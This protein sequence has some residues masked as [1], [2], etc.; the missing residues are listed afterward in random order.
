MRV[1]PTARAVVRPQ[2]PIL[3]VLRKCTAVI[4]VVAGLLIS[5]VPVHAAAPAKWVPGR[6]VVQ[7]RAGVSPQALDDAV[8]FYG[9]KVKGQLKAINAH[10]LAVPAGLEQ[11]V[12]QELNSDGDIA[13]AERERLVAPSA[14]APNDPDYSKAWH[15]AKMQVTSAWDVTRGS[16][17]TVAVLDTG[18]DA[19]QPDLAGQ[20]LPGHNSADGS[21]NTSDVFGHGTEVAGVIAALTNNGIGV[22]SIA[23]AVRILPVRVTNDSKGLASTY[24]IAQGLIWAADHGA[25][26]ANISYNVTGDTLV[27][28]AA[29]Y[30]HSKG[31]VVVVAAGNSDADVGTTDQPNIITV[32]ATTSSDTKASW[33]NYGAAVDVSAPGVGIW[34]TLRG[35][36]YGA[37]SGT[38]FASPATA[39]VAAL[40]M[41]ANPALTPDQ[42]QSVLENSAVDL[43]TPGRDP[44]FGYGRVDAAAAVRLA[45]ATGGTDAQ[46]PSVS[47]TTPGN[48]ATV[49]T[50]IPVDVTASDNVSVSSVELYAGNTKVGTDSV[51]PYQFSWDPTTATPGQT[52]T[53]TAYAHD[54]SG[55]V[56]SASITV[57]VKDQTPPV[58]TPP[59]DELV[60]ATGTLTAVN[61]GTATA[62][63]NFDGPL[64]PTP[65]ATGPFTVGTHVI[66]WTAVDAAG[67]V[68]TATQQIVVTTAD[69]TPPVVT[70]P[71]D[72]TVEATGPDTSVALG[73]GT[74][75]DNVDGNLVPTPDTT[76]PFTVGTHRVVWS[77]IDAAG[78]RGTATQTVKVVDTTPPVITVPTAVTVPAT[79]YVT[80]VTLG[81]ASARDSVSGTVTATA[82][83]PGPFTSG[84]HTVTWTATDKAGNTAHAT[85]TVTVLPLVNLG[86]DQTVGEGSTVTV[87][88]YLSGPAASYPVD[89]PYVVGGTA[90]NPRD[91]DAVAGTLVIGSGTQGS[92]TFHTVN[93]GVTGQPPRTVVF[94]LN[95]PTNAVLGGHDSQTVTITEAKV[96]PTVSLDATQGTRAA[97]TIYPGNGTVTVTAH[98]HD[99]ND[100]ASDSYDWSR[101][102]NALTGTVGN[103]GASFSFDPQGLAPGVYPVR[104]TVTSSADA[105][106][107]TAVTLL[108]QVKS[109]PPV[110]SAS[111][112]SNGDGSSDAADGYGDNDQDGIPNYLDG[113]TDPAVLQGGDG[114]NTRDLLTTEA[115][116]HLALGSTALTAGHRSAGVSAQDVLNHGGRD[117]ASALDGSDT[118]SYPGGLFDFKVTGLADAGQSA[119]VVIPQSVPIPAN[120][121]Y[122]KYV[123]GQGWSGFVVDGHNAIA[124]APGGNGLCPPAGDPSYQSGLRTGD[125]CVELTIQDGGPNDADGAANGVIED[126]S[127]VGVAKPAGVT[128]NAA[129]GGS[130]ASSGGGGGGGCALNPAAPFDP[131]LLL[132]ALVAGVYVVRRRGRYQ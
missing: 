111:R 36:G 39:A 51:A 94:T 9:A 88:A 18:I 103:G 37:V 93:N 15:L 10:V 99:A 132:M 4:A 3:N 69:I 52:V 43:G 122:R 118:F 126:P 120:A 60:E 5:T 106:H 33:S 119:V 84:A 71:P 61:L 6:I 101:S 19:T 91:D 49:S 54:P 129:G 24:D 112:D 26:V 102:D 13:F 63:D 59:P 34:S 77:A 27:Q 130:G 75:V 76:G 35:G 79:G 124:S 23:P 29:A 57:T 107:P 56:G 66:T 21:S 12:A 32:A 72:I 92:I 113:I 81:Q 105:G 127:G 125:S 116:L 20:L 48:G 14:S 11:A 109:T 38:S 28:N 131:S 62:M 85:Q 104:L 121:A 86:M 44:D 83:N 123:A 89:I 117:G 115:G 1:V 128:D 90:S 70:P 96:A 110:L 30:M 45:L 82:V 25:K 16:G 41:S 80:H 65:S 64:T 67:N 95:T 78:N 68:G 100:G 53:L 46:P 17:V 31:G 47:I 22:A 42:V 97:R 74:A 55:N 58:V 8:G 40:V 114:V 108:L 50:V 7:P 98:V 87:T 2:A 73:T